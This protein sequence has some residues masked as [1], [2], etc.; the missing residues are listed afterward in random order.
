LSWIP[1][2]HRSQN[3]PSTI[4]ATCLKSELAHY[5]AKSSLVH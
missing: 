4:S 5:P 2:I 1:A 3:R